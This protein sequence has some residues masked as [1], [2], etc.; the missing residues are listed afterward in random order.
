MPS[1]PTSTFFA[2]VWASV[3]GTAKKVVAREIVRLAQRAGIQSRRG[4]ANERMAS[5]SCQRT[6]GR[7]IQ[8]ADAFGFLWPEGSLRIPLPYRGRG[9]GEGANDVTL[10]RSARSPLRAD[11][12]SGRRRP[13][14]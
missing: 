11:A 8:R 4:K 3:G 1:T 7:S 2:V 9:Q 12:P 10:S 5:Q 13:R 6:Y 14:D